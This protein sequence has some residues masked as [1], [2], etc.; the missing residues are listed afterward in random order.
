MNTDVPTTF[1][2]IRLLNLCQFGGHEMGS[3]WGEICNS[4][5]LNEVEYLF[6]C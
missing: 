4:L 3:H 5:S 2:V 1:D 6:I